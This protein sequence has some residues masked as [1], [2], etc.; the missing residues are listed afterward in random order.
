[1]FGVT[2]GILAGSLVIGAPLILFKIQDHVSLE[3]D[4]KHTDETVDDVVAFTEKPVV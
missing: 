2:W 1:M 3:E 4:L